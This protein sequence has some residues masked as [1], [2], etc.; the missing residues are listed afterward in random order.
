MRE[1]DESLGDLLGQQ[2][3]RV[4]DILEVEV[5][6]WVRSLEPS[7]LK[8]DEIVAEL[9]WYVTRGGKLSSSNTKRASVLAL[10]SACQ[11]FNLVRP[12]M[13][14]EN[15][16]LIKGGRHILY[17]M[18]NETYVSN[19]TDLRSF[20]SQDMQGEGDSVSPGDCSLV[21]T[22]FEPFGM[23]GDLTGCTRR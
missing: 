17:E 4:V 6:K 5:C 13:V 22:L 15:V 14:D 9:D 16:L 23:M 18:A 10:A 2:A 21:S 20:Q 7:L 8:I 11:A 12:R 19:D 1:L 3:D